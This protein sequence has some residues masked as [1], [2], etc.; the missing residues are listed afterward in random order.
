M[1]Q[2][3]KSRHVQSSVVMAPVAM[4]DED[5][6]NVIAFIRSLKE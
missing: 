6:A 3:L 2:V 4:S 1:W 5:M